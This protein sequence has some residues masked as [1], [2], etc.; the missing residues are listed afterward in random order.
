MPPCRFVI[1]LS[2]NIAELVSSSFI[3]SAMPIDMYLTIYE[4]ESEHIFNIDTNSKWTRKVCS[5]YYKL[6]SI[7]LGRWC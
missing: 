3:G 2:Y 4:Y 1:F 5:V 6:I 7:N